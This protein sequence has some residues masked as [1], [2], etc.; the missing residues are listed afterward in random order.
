MISFRMLSTRRGLVDAA[1]GLRPVLL[2]L[3]LALAPPAAQAQT[4][5]PD[6][7]GTAALQCL[8]RRATPPAFPAEE[9]RR[10][11]SAHGYLRVQLVFS[12]ADREPVVKVLANTASEAMQDAVMDYLRSYRLPC[13]N[14]AF[15][16]VSAVQEFAFDALASPE[17]KPLRQTDQGPDGNPKACIV[18]P[19][20]GLEW[21][22]GRLQRGT[23]V[24]RI[25]ARFAGPADQPPAVKVVSSD[26]S[27]ATES[28]VLD[29]LAAYRMPCREAGD[30]PY[31]FEQ[32]FM[33]TPNGTPRAAFKERQLPLGQFLGFMKNATAEQVFF[34][35]NSMACPFQ[36]DWTIWQPQ[37]ANTVRQIGKPNPNRAEFTAWLAAL[38]MDLPERRAKQVFGDR[39]VIDVPC[40]A[41]DFR[42]A[43]APP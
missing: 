4:A 34:D 17:G 23:V 38:Q 21:S 25:E 1:F 2:A 11:R 27:G 26:A 6:E 14:P 30:K 5:L 15:G 41:L 24:V 29:Y 36:L 31:A 43:R 9:L 18:M 10:H 16:P 28:A 37:S 33:F 3:A 7:T 13:M 19:R 8:Q 40:G 12:Q 35:F 32:T 42:E 39:I 22:G 20:T